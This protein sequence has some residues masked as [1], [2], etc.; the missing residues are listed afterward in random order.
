ME[1]AAEGE[2]NDIPALNEHLKL[3]IGI[4]RLADTDMEVTPAQAEALI[5]LWMTVKT[6]LANMLFRVEDVDAVTAQIEA[7]LTPEQMAAIDAMSLTYDD[8]LD[9]MRQWNLN[10]GRY[11]GIENAASFLDDLDDQT[12]GGEGAPRPDGGDAPE[13]PGGGGWERWSQMIP[14]GMI[15]ALIGYLQGI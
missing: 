10:F 1:S 2:T 11:G 13:I 8:M 7:I 4:Y 3:L 5:P 15:D 9:L 12:D 14:P 6:T